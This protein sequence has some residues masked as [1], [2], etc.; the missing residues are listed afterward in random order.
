VENIEGQTTTSKET[1]T[2][3]KEQQGVKNNGQM[4]TSKDKMTLVKE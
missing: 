3:I 2:V 1:M 4:T